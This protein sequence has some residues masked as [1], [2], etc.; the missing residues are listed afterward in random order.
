MRIGRSI[1]LSELIEETMNDFDKTKK[2]LVKE[3]QELRKENDALKKSYEKVITQ[4]KPVEVNLL[5]NEQYLTSILNIVED[6]IFQLTVEPHEHY[7][8]SSVNNAFIRITGIPL[9]RIVGKLVNEIIPEPSLSMVLEK[10]KQAVEAHSIVQWQ[11]TSDYPSGRLI[12]EVSVAPVYN[13]AGICTHLLGTVHDLT[14]GKWI[15]RA[16]KENE[17]RCRQIVENS[18]DFIW[19]VDSSGLYTYCSDKIIKILGYSPDEVVGHKYFYDFFAPEIR[20]DLKTSAFSVF[21]H[22][23]PFRNFINPNTRKNGQTVILETSGSPI[24]DENGNLIGYRGADTDITQRM[25]S[26]QELQHSHEAF[27]NYFELGSV[28][29]CVTSPE[30]NWIEVNARLCQMFGYTKEELQQYTWADLTHPDDLA[31]DV[32]LFNQVLSG[33]RNSYDLD[34]RFIRKDGS[35]LY[36]TLSVTCQRNEDGTLH[37]ILASLIDITDRKLSEQDY[38]REKAF[39]DKLFDSSPEAI[40]VSDWQG[41]LVRVNTKFLELFGFTKEEVISKKIDNLIA[42]DQYHDEAVEITNN[43]AHLGT[44]IEHESIRYRKDGTPVDVSII[45][46]PITVGDLFIGGYGIY[47]DI[48]PR[49]RSEKALKESEEKY[50]AV[51]RTIPDAIVLTQM[52][53]TVVD[54]NFGFSKLSGFTKEEAVGSTLLEMELYS[55]PE[56]R[57]KL[58]K[59]LQTNGMVENLETLIRCKIGS[60]GT[61]LISASIISIN[62]KPLILSI[63]RDI[64]DRK[65]A[66]L[67]LIKQAEE[68]KELNATK[69]KFFSIIAHDLKNPFNTILGFTDILLTNFQEFDNNEILK[70]LNII[71]T[72]SKHAFTLL[73]NLLLWA[74]TQTGTIDFQPEVIDLRSIVRDVIELIKNQAKKK[75]IFVSSSIM[76]H[77]PVFA[78][79][80]MI[81]TILRNLFTNAIKFTPKNGSV[82]VSII[83]QN[84][85]L[86]VSIR[87]TG[88]GIAKEDME[89]IFRIDRKTTNLGTEKEKGTGLGLILCKEFVEKHGGKISVDSELGSGSTFKFT[90]P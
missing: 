43:V 26:E 78:D 88:V 9:E 35:I 40:S 67:Q 3:L 83:H 42:Q 84:N 52:D 1:S 28:G 59:A 29:M 23:E 45:A 46:T 72:S 85:Q 20:D 24:L 12:G 2:E 74:R 50:K 22:K 47:R 11:E 25:H 15:E 51:F 6:V 8:F 64:T 80:N 55:V 37:H 48:T 39:M 58:T 56:D 86:E 4:R 34:K 62:N 36:S 73:E 81:E 54:I 10:Y 38:Q 32:E 30:K 19:E 90:I 44:T 14:E 77:C 27:K 82:V 17:L 16:L 75:E 49:K 70:Y 89:N 53:G 71:D 66:E 76:D 68:L 41:L 57:I 13:E 63:T 79:K 60:L 7:R 18:S 65:L 21:A 33:E 87:D 5:E 61:V 31:A 69:D